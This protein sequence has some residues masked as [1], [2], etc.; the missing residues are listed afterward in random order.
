MA[1]FHFRDIPGMLHIFPCQEQLQGE[2]RR[3]LSWW[4][5]V[6][7]RA[8]LS[9]AQ[10][11]PAA[12]SQRQGWW[13]VSITARGDGQDWG[14]SGRQAS[15]S[16]VR[17]SGEHRH[18]YSIAQMGPRGTP[19]SWNAAPDLRASHAQHLAAL[20]FSSTDPRLWLHNVRADFEAI[21][22]E[23]RK[24]Q[25]LFAALRGLKTFSALHFFNYT[26]LHYLLTII[27][28]M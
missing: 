20:S 19:P 17:C 26:F 21:R 16:R 13:P 15:K 4:V 24:L 6:K 22:E 11:S 14:D 12:P 27:E 2:G 23:G 25:D 18:S 1:L 5:M 10:C 3:A 28:I 9:P 8:A 7:C